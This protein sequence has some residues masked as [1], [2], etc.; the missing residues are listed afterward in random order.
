MTI[1]NIKK[2]KGDFMVKLIGPLMSQA[3]HGTIGGVLT[4]SRRTSKNL[5]RYQR[6]QHD[7]LTLPRKIQRG[8][9]KDA[10]YTW[11]LLS[12]ANKAL[13]AARATASVPSGWAVYVKDY[14]ASLIAGIAPLKLPD[15]TLWTDTKKTYSFAGHNMTILS[16]ADDGVYIWLGVYE[17]SNK[18]IRVLKADPT[19]FDVIPL[20]GAHGEVRAICIDANYVWLALYSDPCEI[21]RVNRANPTV[22]TVHEYSDVEGGFMCMDDDANYLYCGPDRE[23]ADLIRIDKTDPDGYETFATTDVPKAFISIYTDGTYIFG[24]TEGVPAQLVRFL[25]SNPA[26]Q[27]S[28]TFAEGEDAIG[29]IVDDGTHVYCALQNNDSTVIKVLKT[30][31]ADMS[32]FW[33]D[34]N[35]LNF[36]AAA[37]S[38]NYAWF[39]AHTTP[40]CFLRS[41]LPSLG[42]NTL[43]NCATGVNYARALMHDGSF[44]WL[45]SYAQ[46]GYLTKFWL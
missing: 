38:T 35:S 25:V 36:Y 13:W 20:T 45:A 31:L 1:S 4:Y 17:G 6:K 21:V 42:G 29:A 14:I 22:F 28:A 43:V 40:A 41:T 19:Y 18:L 34:G 24:G 44:L 23:P 27:V 3:A 37:I 26:T 11:G 39:A 33:L 15:G 12:A 7:V 2:A 9:F 32:N 5:G 30:N 16:A 8:Y 46:P 10:A